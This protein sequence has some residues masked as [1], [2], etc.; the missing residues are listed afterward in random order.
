MNKPTA[1]AV[2]TLVGVV[3]GAGI[4]GIPYVVARSGIIFGAINII[5]IG[6][7]VLFTNL[8]M[9]EIVLRTKGNHQLTGY[10]EKYLGAAGK[11]I[12]AI[13]MIIGSYGAMLAYTIGEGQIL[14]VVIGGSSLLNSMIFFVLASVI[15]YIGIKAVEESELY[16]SIIF[17]VIVIV[18]ICINL[19]HADIQNL[20]A[21]DGN[22]FLPF[23]VVLFAYLGAQAI[24]A[25]R[26]ELKNNWKHM[27]KAIII[28]SLIPLFV[29]LIFGIS[30]VAVTGAGTTGVASI[31]LG[32]AIGRY[33]VF[34]GNIFAVFSM[35]TS[36]I[37][38]GFV[39][40]EMYHY[41][42]KINDN[43]SFLLAVSLPLILFLLGFKDFI[44]TLSVA[45][46]FSGG[47]MGI[48]IVLMLWNSRKSGER[49]PE[50]KVGLSRMLG[51]LIIAMFLLGIAY[52]I[53]DIL[54]FI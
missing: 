9:G 6:I 44:E 15:V 33:M 13:A 30:V 3:I 51:I 26:E 54:G 31:G 39:L 38:I 35:A 42:F 27:K 7:A 25:M 5:I 34:L 36:F 19:S 29:Y 48:L 53:I 46:S 11:W 12:M 37:V 32:E 4:L 21:G 18:I 52:Q 40:K 23:G 24:P 47:V 41:D 8:F 22:I 17:L 49:D 16:L 45:G 43:L 20:S 14:S 50:F 2:A 10:A 28:G 1:E